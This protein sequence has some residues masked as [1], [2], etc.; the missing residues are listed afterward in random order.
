MDAEQVVDNTPTKRAVPS[1][2]LRTKPIPSSYIP[3]RRGNGESIL[4]STSASTTPTRIPVPRPR[5]TPTRAISTTSKS[6][7]PPSPAISIAATVATAPS[8]PAQRTSIPIHTTRSRL[9]VPVSPAIS[10]AA[11][12]ATASPCPRDKGMDLQR[13]SSEMGS[14]VGCESIYSSASAL[15]LARYR[16]SLPSIDNV[17]TNTGYDHKL[18][19]M[20]STTSF[21]SASSLARHRISQRQS[22]TSSS[23]KSTQ[24]EV[25]SIPMSTNTTNTEDMALVWQPDPESTGSDPAANLWMEIEARLNRGRVGAGAEVGMRDERGQWVLTRQRNRNAGRRSHTGDDGEKVDK[26]QEI[27]EAGGR[28]WEGEGEGEERL[29][30][31]LGS[32]EMRKESS[33]FTVSAY[34]DPDLSTPIAH[35]SSSHSSRSCSY[36]GSQSGGG[37]GLDMEGTAIFNMAAPLVTSISTMGSE[38]GIS[39][40]PA[41]TPLIHYETIQRVSRVRKSY[42]GSTSTSRSGSM[43][44]RMSAVGSIGMMYPRSRGRSDSSCAVVDLDQR[45]VPES[46]PMIESSTAE[47]GSNRDGLESGMIRLDSHVQAALEVL[48]DNPDSPLSSND[49][50][51]DTKAQSSYPDPHEDGQDDPSQYTETDETTP[52]PIP[53][54]YQHTP[55]PSRAGYHARPQV[56]EDYST[57]SVEEVGLGIGMNL[58]LDSI[59]SLPVLSPRLIHRAASSTSTSEGSSTSSSAGPMSSDTDTALSSRGESQD[60]YAYDPDIRNRRGYSPVQGR[61]NVKEKERG[62]EDEEE[63]MLTVTDLDTGHRVD[64]SIRRLDELWRI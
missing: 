38:G 49:L 12:V 22:I 47:I 64:L 24:P 34:F 51:R 4:P 56:P 46:I 52:M 63:E 17:S 44:M 55:T 3:N 48:S 26:N 60:S 32:R 11:T 2:S 33:E 14:E 29:I 45:R 15:A 35:S 39:A 7:L 41:N 23:S 8:T 53:I 18:S 20:S 59:Y 36:V 42:S 62:N 10:V 13:E 57:P 40:T 1:A 5:I 16:A 25:G 58:H 50:D 19:R 9:P 54:P 27:H 43:S 37:T 21:S 30:Q 28:D 31:E 6:R 61:I